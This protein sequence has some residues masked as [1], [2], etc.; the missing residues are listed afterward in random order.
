[1]AQVRFVQEDSS[2]RT[3]EIA[4]DVSVM[5]AAVRNGVLGID[6]D[7]GGCLGCA[8]C[9]VYVEPSQVALLAP[10]STQEVELLANVGA[11]RKPNSRL[12]CQIKVPNSIDQLVVF[13]PGAQ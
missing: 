11:P 6:G 4:E 5:L 3:I 9:H 10:P 7:C 8:T 2:E 1:M 12:S 13:V